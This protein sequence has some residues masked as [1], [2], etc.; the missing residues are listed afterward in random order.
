MHH[1]RVKMKAKNTEIVCSARV[2]SLLKRGG[3]MLAEIFGV[4]QMVVTQLC[5]GDDDRFKY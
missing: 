3:L 5:R 2:I 1:S 4:T